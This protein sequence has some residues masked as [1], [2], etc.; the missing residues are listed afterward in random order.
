MLAARR[1]RDNWALSPEWA[2]AT[3]GHRRPGGSGHTFAPSI[4]HTGRSGSGASGVDDPCRGLSPQE[5]AAK[6]RSNAIRAV[7]GAAV[8][9][10]TGLIARLSTDSTP[11]MVTDLLRSLARRERR[12][13][14]APRHVADL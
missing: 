14:C 12:D 9:D 11:A 3:F 8:R 1:E 7:D 5:L 4:A 6:F 13:G 2:V 10:L